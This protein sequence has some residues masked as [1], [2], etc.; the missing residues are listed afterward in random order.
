[1]LFRSAQIKPLRLRGGVCE[2]SLTDATVGKARRREENWL[3][4]MAAEPAALHG[5]AGRGEDLR[6]DAF[7]GEVGL[8]E[9]ALGAGFADGD[10][11]SIGEAG[12]LRLGGPDLVSAHR[13]ISDL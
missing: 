9:F 4:E 5:T 13:A 8:G 2:S 7:D 1:M 10:D 6:K 3:E 12:L 11:G